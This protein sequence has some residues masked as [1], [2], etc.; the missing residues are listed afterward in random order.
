MRYPTVHKEESRRK[1]VEVASREFRRN[2]I[3]GI[4]VADV[5]KG[6]GLTVGAFYGHFESKEALVR[7]VV[8][9][10]FEA[11]LFVRLKKDGKGLEAMIRAYLSPQ[12]RDRLAVGGGCM[13]A[14]MIE[15]LARHPAE[16]RAI[17]TENIEQIFS[18][19][20]EQLPATIKGVA[21]RK[22]A[23]VLFGTLMGTLQLSR[24]TGDPKLSAQ[25]LEAGVGAALAL[26]QG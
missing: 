11:S 18:L 13:A 24:A 7:E 25:I 15:E 2:G 14:A 20:E 8:A 9:E 17:F 23:T 16:T 4:G 1:I 6:A 5:M 22:T 12:H 21:R 19:L 26:V 10:A 3:D